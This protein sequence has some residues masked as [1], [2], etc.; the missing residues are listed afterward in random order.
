M[1]E[2]N[3]K[4]TPDAANNTEPVK[5]RFKRTLRECYDGITSVRTE[6]YT[7]VW[8]QL[9]VNFTVGAGA[10]AMLILSM[11]LKARAVEIGCAIGGIAAII[12]LV[13][14]NYVQ[15]SI[16]PAS[17]LQYTYIDREKGRRFTYQIL[18]KTRAVF[19]DGEHVIETNRSS[20]AKL[21]ALPFEQ[22][23]Y[24]YFVK[25][26]PLERIGEADRET[27]KGVLD[28]GGRRYKCS[29]VIKGG[30]PLYGYVGGCRIKFFDINNT[31]EKFVVPYTLK[32]AAT[33]LKIQ[34]PK[35]P[36]LFIRDMKD[37]TKQ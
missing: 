25:M 29:V 13:L 16:V 15:H 34:F 6:V 8:W 19:C 10:L 3:D 21:D 28:F 27:Y 12:V 30:R 17:F 26:D 22:Y 36:G 18:S 33:Q 7:T 1:A 2:E 31:K 24:D 23:S 14:F 9:V 11:V 35:I 37:L 20:A 32:L 4:N 5:D